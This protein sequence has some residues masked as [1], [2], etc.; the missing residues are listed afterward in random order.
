MI[1]FKLYFS[2]TYLSFEVL[3][4]MQNVLKERERKVERERKKKKEREE[5]ERN[6]EG[7]EIGSQSSRSVFRK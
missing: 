6:R 5:T 3:L 7:D 1:T 2:Y 4:G